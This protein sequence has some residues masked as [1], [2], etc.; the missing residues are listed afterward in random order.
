MALK[1]PYRL[2]KR[3]ARHGAIKVNLRDYVNLSRLPT[4]P[5]EYGHE[6]MVAGPWGV[7]GNAN[8]GCCFWSGSAHEHMVWN[9][10]G[11]KKIAFDTK[12]VLS[13]YSAAT[14]FQTSDPNSDQGTDMQQGASYR[15]KVGIAD[16][17]GVRHKVAAYAAIAPRD[18]DLLNVAAYCFEAV[19]YGC[20]FPSSAMKQFDA[21]QPF[22]LV[23]NARIEGGHYMPIVG[24]RAGMF[25]F[26]TWGS[27]NPGD[28]AWTEA[29]N[30]ENV[31]YFSPEM[32]NGTKTLEGFDAEH[33]LDT[34][35]A[36]TSGN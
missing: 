22:S 11:H 21:G 13:D 4:P 25:I 3:P 1:L 7:L 19:G 36:L 12:A 2:G 24:R 30:D 34:I 31:C 29:E 14:G 10:A 18:L 35:K 8:Y 33:L 26:S 27:L 16:A 17:S 5:S 6:R 23:P 20:M 32:L 15:R 9:A 28:D